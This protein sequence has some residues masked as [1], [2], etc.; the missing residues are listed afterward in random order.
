MALCVRLLSVTIT[1]SSSPRSQHLTI[2]QSFLWPNTA[3]WYVHSTPCLSIHW[4]MDILVI[5]TFWLSNLSINT[6]THFYLGVIS[7][8]WGI[9]LGVELLGQMVN[10]LF[11]LLGNFQSDF[12]FTFLPTMYKGSNSSTFP[13]ILAIVHVFYCN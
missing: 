9:Y 3:P 5:L 11:N 12:H 10:S 2:P 7:F 13:P 1:F 4:L 6:N 8:L